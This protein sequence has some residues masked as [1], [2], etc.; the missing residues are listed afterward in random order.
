MKADET[1]HM[2]IVLTSRALTQVVTGT[3][4][5][6]SPKK[7]SRWDWTDL[8]FLSGS[9]WSQNHGNLL[10]SFSMCLPSP[11]RSFGDSCIN[12]KHQH[13]MT[14]FRVWNASGHSVVILMTVMD[15][16]HVCL[17]CPARNNSLRYL[18]LTFYFL[19]FPPVC[20]L[21][22]SGF[23]KAFFG[24]LILIN[25]NA[26]ALENVNV[27]MQP[28]F[29]IEHCTLTVSPREPPF[30]SFPRSPTSTTLYRQCSDAL[31][32]GDV[33][34]IVFYLVLTYSI[35]YISECCSVLIALLPGIVK[36]DL[37][38]TS[39]NKDGVIFQ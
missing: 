17:V 37:K 13:M 4:P 39:P 26:A 18:H 38:R 16:W 34:L 2:R 29:N 31:M 19:H 15:W 24:C 35:L 21:T 7:T 6:V 32:D 8:H 23:F 22:I 9:S 1:G 27:F 20:L 30:L 28:W 10:F 25:T 5:K 11:F 14:V 3:R 36:Q 33:T 12:V